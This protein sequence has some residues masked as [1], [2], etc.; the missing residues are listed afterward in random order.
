MHKNKRIFFVCLCRLQINL[1]FPKVKYKQMKMRFLSE[2]KLI[3][4]SNK[5]YSN[6]RKKSKKLD[7]CELTVERMHTQS[8][9]GCLL[10]TAINFVKFPLCSR[11]H[12]FVRL[13]LFSFHLFFICF[14]F[15][16]A[17]IAKKVKEK[18]PYSP[19]ICVHEYWR[20]LI[21]RIVCAD[22]FFD[23]NEP[24]NGRN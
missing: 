9:I 22:E 18:L 12:F 7:D 1:Q 15:A 21:V 24:D 5:Y 20:L 8:A 10:T 3:Y 17:A 2:A 16:L 6:I 13:F 4:I 19:L 23:T 14:Y 11:F